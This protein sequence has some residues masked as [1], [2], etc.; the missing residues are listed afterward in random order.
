MKRLLDDTY[1]FLDCCGSRPARSL[2]QN[3]FMED[4]LCVVGVV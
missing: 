4:R 1:F 3:Y 2:L